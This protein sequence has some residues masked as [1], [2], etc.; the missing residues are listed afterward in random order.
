[1]HLSRFLLP[2]CLLPAAALAQALPAATNNDAGPAGIIPYVK[3]YNIS[4]GT[5]SEHD[6]SNGWST[7]LTPD[8]AYRFNQHFSAD[9]DIPIY[10]YINVLVNSGTKARPID[11]EQTKHF[12]LADSALNTHYQNGPNHFIDYEATLTAGFPTGDDK[13][14]LGAGQFTYNFNNRF[15]KSISFVTPGIELGIGDNSQLQNARV[16]RDYTSVGELA[17]FQAG[18]AFDL[19]LNL[20]FSS[21]A[22]EELPI[23]GQTI[24][25]TTGKGKKKVTTATNTGAA[26]DNGFLNTLDIPLQRHITLS[27]FYNRSLRNHID[28]AGFTLTFLLK[29]PPQNATQ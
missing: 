29:A 18:A 27:G 17:F 28:T 4:V 15:E 5:T 3:G 7:V 1:M 8:L 25:S 26:E 12:A 16:R 23:S 22:Y 10:N 2:F 19:P 9:F 20:T 14:G 13:D 11:T 21:A 24:F 6:S